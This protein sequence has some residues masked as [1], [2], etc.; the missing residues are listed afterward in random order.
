MDNRW[1]K[2]PRQSPGTA[3]RSCWIH[4]TT[5]SMSVTPLFPSR[6]MGVLI[7]RLV[8]S[9]FVVI[10]FGILYV[11]VLVTP[12]FLSRMKGVEK[13]QV[14]TS[15]V[16]VSARY[17]SLSSFRRL[18]RLVVSVGPSF[19]SSCSSCYLNLVCLLVV[20]YVTLTIVSRVSSLSSRRRVRR[21]F[22]VVVFVTPS[23]I[24]L[25]STAL[26]L[27]HSPTFS[28]SSFCC[29][30]VEVRASMVG[31]ERRMV[32]VVNGMTIMVV[33]SSSIQI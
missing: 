12:S 16:Y 7:W 9:M 30:H 23:I 19:L 18:V 6:T 22:A 33:E 21:A 13:K 4:R 32:E 26:I 28:T 20:T 14:S 15:V 10:L 5:V 1:S 31:V 27:N 11:M 25:I 17:V 8:T 2:R 24:F 29:V 3:E